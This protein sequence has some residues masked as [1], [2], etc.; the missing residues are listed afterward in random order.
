MGKVE[1][2]II[3]ERPNNLEEL[4]RQKQYGIFLQNN[5]IAGKI[6]KKNGYKIFN[7]NEANQDFRKIMK[8]DDIQSFD[9]SYVKDSKGKQVDK[10]ITISK[11]NFWNAF[12]GPIW[13]NLDL[14]KKLLSVE[15]LFNEI[16]QKNGLQMKGITYLPEDIALRNMNGYSAP[17]NPYIFFSIDNNLFAS[18]SQLGSVGVIAHELEHKKQELYIKK[19]QNQNVNDLFSQYLKA[20]YIEDGVLPEIFLFLSNDKRKIAYYKCLPDEKDARFQ[21]CKTLLKYRALNTK[22]F[23]ADKKADRLLN[24]YIKA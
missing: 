15:W 8:L 22:Q 11:Q 20:K 10:N 3:K 17:N 12:Y 24:N 19:Y 5:L 16:N 23:G 14:Q 13:N 9:A 7:I 1:N 4:K 21:E 2:N 6:L 18:G